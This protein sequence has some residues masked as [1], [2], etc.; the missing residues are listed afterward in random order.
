MSGSVSSV[1]DWGIHVVECVLWDF[2]DT[3]ADKSWMTKAPAQL[4]N[5]PYI[6]KQLI[7]EGQLGIDWNLGKVQTEEIASHLAPIIHDGHRI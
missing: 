2:G 1:T 3:L 6:Y 4:S 5:W 7:W